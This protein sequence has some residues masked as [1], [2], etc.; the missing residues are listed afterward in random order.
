MLRAVVFVPLWLAL[1]C[2]ASPTLADSHEVGNAVTGEDRNPPQ[3]IPFKQAEQFSGASLLRV[4]AILVFVLILAVAVIIVLKKIILD[5]SVI[6]FPD[7]RIRL[8]EARRLSSR[9]SVFL[10]VVD[11]QE[12]LISQTGE[13]SSM[14]RHESSAPDKFDREPS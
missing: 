12:Y 4:G 1:F 10:V 6:K 11:E 13:S 3:S 2:A 7:S 8:L 14:L 9:L 5:R